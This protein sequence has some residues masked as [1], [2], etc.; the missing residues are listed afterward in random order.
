M[1]RKELTIRAIIIGVLG[2]VVVAMSS[3]YIALRMGALPWPTVFVALTS[4]AVLNSL[5]NT[6]INEINVAHT[7][8]SAGGLIAP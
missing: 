6:S 1:E 7:A 8:M 3:T 4:F 2:S 5:G